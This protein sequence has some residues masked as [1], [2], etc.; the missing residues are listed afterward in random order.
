MILVP[1]AELVVVGEELI[2]V[3]AEPLTQPADLGVTACVV[4]PKVLNGPLI[5]HRRTTCADTRP[6]SWRA[7]A[8]MAYAG[9]SSL[10]RGNRPDLIPRTTPRIK[11]TRCALL[12]AS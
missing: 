9:S 8:L 7:K 11:V 3:T 12:W 1:I 10:R 6:P 5:H 4:L 2:V